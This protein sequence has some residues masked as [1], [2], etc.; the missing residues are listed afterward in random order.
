V[1]A[2][3]N[4]F[5]LNSA[6]SDL[7]AH[8]DSR[9]ERWT[10]RTLSQEPANRD[11][12]ISF[13]DAV[14]A[15]FGS[16]KTS[17]D[18]EVNSLVSTMAGPHQ[19]WLDLMRRQKRGFVRIEQIITRHTSIALRAISEGRPIP[20]GV[21][22]L[23]DD[24]QIENVFEQSKTFLDDLLART[25]VQQSR[26]NESDGG[27]PAPNTDTNGSAEFRW[28]AEV[29]A[30][31]EYDPEWN[32]RGGGDSPDQVRASFLRL[33]RRASIALGQRFEQPPATVDGSIDYT[34][35]TV[36]GTGATTHPRTGESNAC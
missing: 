12:E 26:Q 31:T 33:T 34:S 7:V 21:T 10:L 15:A 24:G 22:E 25:S 32:L 14:R 16:L 20:A 18:P 6:L 27:A 30:D 5:D 19:A 3:S 9:Q 17:R 1:P 36:P 4:P 23:L 13:K 2:M 35:T 11:F 29:Y 8:W 28:T